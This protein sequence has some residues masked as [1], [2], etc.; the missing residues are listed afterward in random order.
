MTKAFELTRKDA[1]IES[2]YLTTLVAVAEDV[3]C[4]IYGVRGTLVSILDYTLSNRLFTR[5]GPKPSICGGE[6][7]FECR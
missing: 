6:L 7:Q 3:S 4:D 5:E 2:D 1:G